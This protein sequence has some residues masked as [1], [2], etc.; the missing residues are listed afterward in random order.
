[1]IEKIK[2]ICTCIIIATT[3][4]SLIVTICKTKGKEEKQHKIIQLAQ[5]VQKL[6]GIISGIEQAV[7]A[8]NGNIK[9]LL[10]LNQAQIECNNAGVEY[11]EE[12]FKNEIEK[13]L[14]TP[15]KKEQNNNE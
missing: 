10:A 6:P 11:N 13:I 5:I 12:Q 9:L 1:M 3:I 4:I 8:G 15:H 7:G 2:L 14:E